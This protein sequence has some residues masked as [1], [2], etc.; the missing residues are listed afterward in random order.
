M[1]KGTVRDLIV[2]ILLAGVILAGCSSPTPTSF[3][4]PQRTP[5]VLS[6]ATPIS[7]ITATSCTLPTVVVPTLPA[8]IPGYT[9]LDP[10]TGLHMTGQFQEIDLASYRLKV[11]GKVDYP[12]ELTYDELRCMPKTQAQLTL[13]CPGFFEDVA[14]W[15][16][17]PIASVL[18]L[19]HVQAGATQVD[20]VSADGYVVSVPLA[21]AG[22]E[23]NFLAYEW[24]GRPLPILHGFPVRAVFPAL[25]G[26]KWIKW[27]MQVRVR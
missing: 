10:T 21:T 15:A 20:L 23:G 25:D 4:A 8:V 3:P 19:A 12:L 14:V 22:S 1:K 17:T 27:L 7:T 26:S 16:G 18:R 24:E 11:T 6:P 5:E 2:G 13:I 9:D